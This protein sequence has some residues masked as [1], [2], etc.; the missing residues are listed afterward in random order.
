[1]IVYEREVTMQKEHNSNILVS[2]LMVTY[3]HEEY[4]AQAL[5]SILMQDVNF[6]YEIIIGEDCSTDNTRQILLEYKEKYPDKIK[7][8]LY[9]QNVGMLKNWRTVLESSSSK[10]NAILEGDDYWIDVNKLQMQIDLM[11]ENPEC[12]MSFH[13]AKIL[14]NKDKDGKIIAKHT[15][16]NKI[17]STSEVILGGGGFCPTGSIM[18]RNE[19]VSTLPDLYFDAPVGDYMLQIFGSL[20]GGI[21]YIDQVMSVYRKGI[22][23]SWSTSMKNIEKRVDFYEKYIKALDE[24]DV[25][26]DHKYQ[27]EL[28]HEK[29]KRGYDMAVFYLHN[30]M[31]KE[32]KK[33]IELSY[34]TYPLKSMF[35]FIDYHIRYFPRLIMN[36]KI[37]KLKLTA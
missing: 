18:F 13:A 32:F 22:E 30:G 7:L 24:L 10:Y 26:F 3:N 37:L 31:F 5:E 8:L 6:N 23:V 20:N 15:S 36:L 21:L 1:M 25:Y 19:V 12:H 2:I 29:S 14:F 17:F 4:I 34:K 33:Y 27:N 9:D 35:Y 16:G 28:A 11:E